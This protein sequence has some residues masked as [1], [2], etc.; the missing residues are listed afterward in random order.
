MKR[1]AAK[2][3]T[4]TI[5]SE[6]QQI[7]DMQTARSQFLSATLNMGWRLAITVV[8][9]IVLGVKLDERFN[10]A[11]SLTLLGLFIATTAGCMAVWSTIQEINKEQ[12]EEAKVKKVKGRR[13]RAR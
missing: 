11:P 8:I 1:A 4:T 13:K 6:L 3:T 5:E 9:P 7:A 10:T 12:A 2:K